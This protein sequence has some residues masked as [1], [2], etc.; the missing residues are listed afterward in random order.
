MPSLP[1]QL[2]LFMLGA[3]LLTIFLVMV[4]LP[5]FRK[6]ITQTVRT[7]VIEH[8]K[9]K[10]G[11]PTMGGAFIVIPMLLSMF[12]LELSPPVI[13]ALIAFFGFSLIGG[14]DDFLKQKRGRGSGLTGKQKSVFM[15][16]LSVVIIYRLSFDNSL[17]LWQVPF[18]NHII[19]LSWLSLPSA[20][21][22]ILGTSNAVN[23]T[24]GLDGLLL[25]PFVF[26]LLGFAVI[27]FV[28]PSSHQL[29]PIIF[30]L[31]GSCLALLCFNI[32]PARLFI[33]DTGSL[34]LGG[35]LATIALLMQKALLLVPLG[36]LFVLEALS[37]ILQ[38]I[39]FQTT[40]KR[41]FRMS[42]LH[43]HF[44]LLGHSESTIACY[45]WLFSLIMVIITVM[46]EVCKWL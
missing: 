30:V 36:L 7:D 13:T 20:L 22:V 33:G 4:L 12:F 1:L 39:S 11:T 27:N 19:D 28:E 18:C 9:T 45:A 42:P 6:A 43:H 32:N 40:G 31:L 21:F 2:V 37:V 35:V 3:M 34:G 8:H 25:M 17:Q 5:Y 23:L 29:L 46:L 38:V 26:S 15:L 41:I 10:E 44:E 16:I 14:L 24:D